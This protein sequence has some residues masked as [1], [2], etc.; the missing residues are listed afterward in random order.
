MRKLAEFASESH[1]RRF[2]D[3]LFAMGI[4]ARV[5][6]NDD[7]GEAVES[8]NE[9][10]VI[11]DA[12]LERARTE[13]EVY[14]SAPRDTR[15]DELR[16]VA[17][18]RRASA[19][20]AQ[21][22]SR[23]REIEFA[24]RARPKSLLELPVTGAVFLTCAT[25]FYL[26]NFEAPRLGVSPLYEALRYDPGEPVRLFDLREDRREASGERADESDDALRLLLESERTPAPGFPTSLDE[27]TDG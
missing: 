15:Y 13:Y 12:H 3:V 7:R 10:W 16:I 25:F 23:H 17:Q 8:S 27:D 24:D 19:E 9:V 6:V 26:M 5:R 11:D 22:E 1:A 21:T 2:V 4:D 14:L 20:S 18:E